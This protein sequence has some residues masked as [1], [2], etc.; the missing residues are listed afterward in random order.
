M[1]LVH[2]GVFTAFGLLYLLV[3]PTKWRAWAL[4]MGSVFAI[5]WLQPTLNIRWLDYSLPTAT[6]GITVMGWMITR[7]PQENGSK[8]TREDWLTIGVIVGIA[9]LLTIS[10]YVELPIAITSRPPEIWQAAICLFF[11]VGLVVVLRKGSIQNW[12]I[13]LYILAAIGLFIVLKTEGLS[14]WLS[15]ILRNQTGQDATL[16]SSLDIQW[17]GFSYVAF[18]LI[19]T[20]RDRQSGLLPDLTLR[21]YTTYVI[22]FPAYAAGPIDRVERFSG[23]YRALVTLNG[24]DANRIALGLSRITIGLFKKFIV[25]D[26]LAFFSLSATTLSQAQ[27]TAAVWVML[28]SYAIRL[29]FDFSGYSDIA[30]GIGM[31]FGIQL[32]ENFDRPYL[33]NNITAFWQSWHITLSNWVRAYVY[34][35][36]SRTLLKRTSKPSNDVIILICTL[37]TMLVIGLWH[38]INV[39]FALWGLWHGL[40]L[41]IHKLWSDRTREWYRGL[42]QRPIL[43][44]VWQVTG[45]LLTFHFVLLG[46][47]WFALPD[48]ASAMQAIGN[49]IG[50]TR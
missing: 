16:A 15:S 33:K 30:I 3:L 27:S 49:L 24:R 21:E 8:L 50:I 2:I 46:W 41:F 28:Y 1:E 12:Q 42:K 29:Y 5:Y 25:A 14:H 37:S 17:L 7:K 18:R 20:L 10:R 9:L 48:T 4:L 11:L 6:L 23:D 32:P 26:S 36:L 22:F 43:A 40:G 45:V 47:V 13:S 31:L 44:R 35:P 34:S 39:P 19:H 38:G